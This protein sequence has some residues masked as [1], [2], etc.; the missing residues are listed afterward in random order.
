MRL[1]GR[2]DDL[3]EVGRIL[4]ICEQ[5]TVLATSRSRAER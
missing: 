2:D 3:D 5:P 1:L 4:K